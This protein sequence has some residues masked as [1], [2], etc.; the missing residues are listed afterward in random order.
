MPY[1]TVPGPAPGQ[2]RGDIRNSRC[3]TGINDTGGKFATGVVVCEKIW[4]GPNGIISGLGE[5]I[6][7]KSQKQK[8]RDTVP[9]I[10][11]LNDKQ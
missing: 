5:L 2:I 10:V 3:T 1:L 4:N 9:L 7:E 8:S 6:D 11:I